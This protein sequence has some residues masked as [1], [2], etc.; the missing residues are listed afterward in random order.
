MTTLCW[1]SSLCT[2]HVVRATWLK[3]WSQHQVQ[4]VIW[5]L[6]ARNV[7]AAEI[8]HTIKVYANKINQQNAAKWCLQITS[9]W[10][11]TNNSARNG[12]PTTASTPDK[13]MCL[14]CSFQKYKNN[15]QWNITKLESVPWNSFQEHLGVW[16]PQGMYMMGAVSTIRKAQNKRDDF[17]SSY[18]CNNM[19]LV[20][21]D[22]SS[23]L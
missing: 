4:A 18:S 19:L 5:F 3:H 23:A 2:A 6:Y 13:K 10:T 9:W 22:F 17:V 11:S 1:G 15:D 20:T 16:I 12:R 7:S 14:K 21:T 8:C